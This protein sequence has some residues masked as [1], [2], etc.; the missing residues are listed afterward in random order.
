MIRNQAL[1]PRSTD[2]AADKVEG[3]ENSSENG[4]VDQGFLNSQILLFSS[5][6][7]SYRIRSSDSVL[8]YSKPKVLMIMCVHPLSMMD[9]AIQSTPPTIKYPTIANCLRQPRG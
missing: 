8:S 4:H 9:G 6:R 5:L 3:K 1:Q 7:V 2:N